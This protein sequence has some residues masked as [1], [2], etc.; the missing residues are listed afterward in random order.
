VKIVPTSPHAAVLKHAALAVTHCGHGT[1]IRALAA[2]VPLVCMP[3]GRDQNDT[4]ARVVNRGAGVRIKPAAKPG[5][6]KKAIETVLANPRYAAGARALADAITREAG[7][8]I[9]EIEA[10]TSSAKPMA[11]GATTPASPRS[12][13]SAAGTHAR[14][15]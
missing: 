2:G 6:I 15:G 13:A 12:A 1:T 5:A 11:G 3:M 14:A 4:A 9:A 7:D 8:P 10:I